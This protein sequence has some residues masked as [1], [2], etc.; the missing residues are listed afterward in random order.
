[1]IRFAVLLIIGLVSRS[2]VAGDLPDPALTPG[3]INPAIT[4]GNLATTVCS[5]PTK[6]AGGRSIPWTAN[7]RPPASF[8]N[9]LKAQQM[10]ALGLVGDP[11]LW[12]EDHRVPLECGGAPRDPKNLSPQLW[13]GKCNAHVKD[14]L[15]DTEHRRMCAGTIT[16]AQCQAVFLGDWT[17][18][19]AKLFGSCDR[20]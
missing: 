1:M 2:A 4:Q 16:L 6:S 19:Y 15:E 9:K 8:T 18:E 13:T 11:H 5:K 12:E 3:A 10:A 20:P 14:V 7:I 17:V